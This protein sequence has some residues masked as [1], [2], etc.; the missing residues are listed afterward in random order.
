MIKNLY[1]KK[2]NHLLQASEEKYLLEAFCLKGISERKV[3]RNKRLEL[4]KI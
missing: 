1:K 3:K 4:F 2:Y